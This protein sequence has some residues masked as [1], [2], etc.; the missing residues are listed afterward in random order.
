VAISGANIYIVWQEDSDIS[1]ARS[2]DDGA[3][4]GASVNISNNLGLSAQ[5]HVAVS[6][7]RV[8]VVWTDDT[9][10]LSSASNV[11]FATSNDNGATF[12]A[13]L[14]VSMGNFSDRPN[15]AVSGANVYLTW[16]EDDNFFAP[17]VLFARST[18][19]GATF[20]AP[21]NLSNNG[22]VSL[23]SQLAA[24]ASTIYVVWDDDTGNPGR[25]RQH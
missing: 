1:L 8:Y 20:A 12:G 7:S 19:N 6:G 2:T 22:G 4:F 24:A 11:F 3:S 23:N 18:D 10:T 15:I 13:A 9:G 21:V 5:P 25:E 16:Q 14:N 17:D